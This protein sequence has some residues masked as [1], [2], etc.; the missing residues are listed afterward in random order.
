[1]EPVVSPGSSETISKENRRL[2]SSSFTI[3]ILSSHTR[4]NIDTIRY[5]ER[6]GLLPAP[7]RT[8]GGHRVY[9]PDHLK[10]LTFIRRSRQLGFT[11]EDVRGL[12]ELVDGNSYTCAEVKVMTLDHVAS[13]RRKIA[14]LRKLERVLKE[15]A[16]QCSGDE[17][18]DC[19]VID[20]LFSAS[21]ASSSVRRRRG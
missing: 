11:L 6:A 18:P 19:P 12:L 1:M 14:D 3:G 8:T 10:R 2:Q 20:A 4:C 7:P 15:M 17:V 13:I 21:A 9:G 16:A 5:Y